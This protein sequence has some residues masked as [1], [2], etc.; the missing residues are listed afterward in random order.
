LDGWLKINSQWMIDLG[1]TNKEI[2]RNHPLTCP[3]DFGWLVE[4]K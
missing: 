2:I 4:N 3:A 1:K